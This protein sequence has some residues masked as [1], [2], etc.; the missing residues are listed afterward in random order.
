MPL[1]RDIFWVGRQWTVT[2][3]GMQAV[4]QRL[5]GIF[6]IEIAGLW[7][8]GL[9]ERMRGLQWL[10]IE[11]FDKGLA[12]ARKRYPAP[13]GQATPSE[14][15]SSEV[16]SSEVSEP[17]VPPLQDDASVEL[18]RPMA[19]PFDMQIESS[20]AKFVSTWRIRRQR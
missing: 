16:G 19:Q 5:K 11:D 18:S 6:D 3:Y 10:N 15:G 9:T 2:G 20:P 17:V 1:H 4:D 14:V 13:P 12:V 7:E 8:D